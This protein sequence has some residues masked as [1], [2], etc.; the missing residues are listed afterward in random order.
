MLSTYYLVLACGVLAVAYGAFA[1][2]SIMSLPTGTDRMQEIAAAVQEGAAAYLKRQ[3]M[4]I[5]V[6]GVVVCRKSVV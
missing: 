4:T 5:G 6:V 2:K 3:Y 1:V